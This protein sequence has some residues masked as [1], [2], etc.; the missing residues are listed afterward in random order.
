MDRHLLL[1]Q[2]CVHLRLC[3][4]ACV[5]VRMYASVCVCVCVLGPFV[6]NPPAHCFRLFKKSMVALSESVST[7]LYFLF[8]FSY[9]GFCSFIISSRV[10]ARHVARVGREVNRRDASRDVSR[11]PANHDQVGVYRPVTCADRSANG[12]VAFTARL[13]KQLVTVSTCMSMSPLCGCMY[14]HTTNS[15]YTYT[16]HKIHTHKHT[17]T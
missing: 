17:Q 6:N 3:V 15:K 12:N 14:R 13:A 4:F 8:H 2:I 1:L 10:A 11:R 5:Y 9:S 7:V 16:K